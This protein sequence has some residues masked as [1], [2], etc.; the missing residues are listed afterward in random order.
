[1]NT[2]QITRRCNEIYHDFTASMG[3]EKEYYDKQVLGVIIYMYNHTEIDHEEV[4]WLWVNYLKTGTLDF[5]KAIM[6]ARE[7]EAQEIRET[8]EE[9]I[10]WLHRGVC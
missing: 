5:A 2:P 8:E 4:E 1:M 7:R 9:L 3:R 6:Y 10:H